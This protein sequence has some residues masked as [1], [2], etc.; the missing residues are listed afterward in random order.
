MANETVTKRKESK[1]DLQNLSEKDRNFLTLE[2][3]AV[4]GK[5]NVGKQS[6]YDRRFALN[7]KLR[8]AG[9][10][11]KDVLKNVKSEVSALVEEQ[12]EVP[13]KEVTAKKKTARKAEQIKAERDASGLK[14]ATAPQLRENAPTTGSM[15]KSIEV[16]FENFSLK[17]NGVLKKIWLNPETN[18]I[19]IIF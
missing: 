5:Y 15:M 16:K 7:K 17:L 12:A 8:A 9:L 6:V 1:F 18:A 13:G 10:A 11:V 14:N 3:P 19:E 4:M 2:V